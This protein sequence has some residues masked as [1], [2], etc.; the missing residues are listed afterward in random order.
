MMSKEE[1]G[2]DEVDPFVLRPLRPFYGWRFDRLW[3][4]EEKQVKGRKSCWEQARESAS[5]DSMLINWHLGLQFHLYLGHDLSR[6]LYIAGCYEPNALFALDKLIKPG[7]TVVDVGAHEGLFSLFCAKKVNDTGSVYS[8]EPSPRE[9]ERLGKNIEINEL[10][11]VQLS[12]LALTDKKSTETLII[13]EPT[14]SGQNTLG[15]FV[16]EGIGEE[17]TVE[18]D[19]ISLDEYAASNSIDSIDFI[20]VDAEGCEGRILQGA[21]ECLAKSRPILLFEYLPE[22]LKKQGSDPAS[23]LDQLRELDY[24]LYQFMNDGLLSVVEE[25][26]SEDLLALPKEFVLPQ[27]LKSRKA[28]SIGS[29]LYEERE[30]LKENLE[31][32]DALRVALGQKESLQGYQWMQWLAMVRSFQPDLIIQI[33][34]GQGHLTA[35]MTY[36]LSTLPES[37]RGKLISIGNND[38]FQS[39]GLAA[40]EESLDSQSLESLHLV[41]LEPMENYDFGSH[42]AKSQRPLIVWQSYS[43]ELAN[44]LFGSVLSQIYDREHLVVLHGLTDLSVHKGMDRRYKGRGF[45]RESGRD[46]GA[47]NLGGIYSPDGKSLAY[48]DF[49]ERNQIEPLSGD[50]ALLQ[51]FNSNQEQAQELLEDL[52]EDY[53]QKEAHWYLLSLN[54]CPGP[55][56]FPSFQPSKQCVKA[57]AWRLNPD[58]AEEKKRG[59]IPTI[60]GAMSNQQERFG[61]IQSGYRDLIEEMGFESSVKKS[62]WAQILSFTLEFHPDLILELGRGHG[63]STLML[64]HGA[65]L[66]PGCHL[67]SIDESTDWDESTVERVGELVDEDWFSSLRVLSQAP[68]LCDVESL[69]AGKQRIVIYI[70]M[71]SLRVM[72]W[73][74]SSLLPKIKDLDHLILAKN[75][76]DSRYNT[77][78]SNYERGLWRIGRGQGTVHLGHLTSGSEHALAIVDFC[79]RNHLPLHSIDKELHETWSDGTEKLRR[80]RKAIGEDFFSLCGHWFYFSMLEAPGDLTFPVS[81]VEGVAP[82]AEP[83][84]EYFHCP[85]QGSTN[86]YELTVDSAIPSIASAFENQWTMLLDQRTELLR[87]QEAVGHSTDL[88]FSQWN[89]L[90]AYTLEFK[91][92]LIIELGRGR[93]NSTCLFTQAAKALGPDHSCHVLSLCNSKDWTEETAPKL[94]SKFG[95]EWF[96]DLTTES[97]DILR[98]DPSPFVAKAKRV[99]VFWDAHGFEIAEWMLGAVLPQLKDKPHAILM[100]DMTDTRY[101]SGQEPYRERPLWMGNNWSGPRLRMGH[102]DSAVEQSI[103]IIDFTSRNHLPL[104]SADHSLHYEIGARENRRSFFEDKLGKDAFSLHAHWFYFTLKDAQVPVNFPQYQW[105][106]VAVHEDSAPDPEPMEAPEEEKKKKHSFVLKLKVAGGI[107]LGRV[108]IDPLV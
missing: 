49:C 41:T 38:E 59:Q 47:L 33:G 97:C 76:T 21:K 25:V 22:S 106:A 75:M 92:D 65:R 66:I 48:L 58:S 63:A 62:Q 42:L 79:S 57:S 99:M 87:L 19:T 53:F 55:L 36:A 64:N 34:R 95:A 54:N 105:P 107:L 88:N 20:K 78:N 11:H 102:I 70:E 103:A 89:Q 14:H 69:I 101:N 83:D 3:E 61:E 43:T 39:E 77:V 91:P 85:E 45:W 82:A 9:R 84:S 80:L 108:P 37:D 81:D 18:V 5:S 27:S 40:L 93:G 71:T 13:A 12:E 46:G 6:Q 52:G 31:K 98:Y 23:I 2:V 96:Q 32:V 100:H 50:S 67:I 10:K 56:Y 90:F 16:H 28:F 51:Y 24:Q 68:E 15:G 8:F 60:V 44:C 17:S 29:S 73:V 7:M 72:N 30:A 35:A 86:N 4:S 74:F 1:N 104:F 94:E 26:T